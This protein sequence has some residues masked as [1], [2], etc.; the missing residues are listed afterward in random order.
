MKH[1]L[2]AAA[3]FGAAAVQAAQ[4]EWVAAKVVKVDPERSRVTLDHARIKSIDMDAMVMPFK[5]E[6]GVD[7]RRFK[8]G[9]R[10]RF[11][12][13]NKDDHLVVQAMEK[14]K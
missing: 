2:F 3:L 14:A 8:P 7:L 1:W 11:T 10:V 4:Q 9:D 5:V 6:A 13:S 12:V